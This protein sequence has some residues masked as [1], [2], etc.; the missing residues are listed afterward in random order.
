MSFRD[1]L[2]GSSW[3]GGGRIRFAAD[4]GAGGAGAGG[5]AAPAGGAPGGGGGG[6][7]VPEWLAPV[8][9]D[10]RTFIST[11]G[12]KPESPAALISSLGKGYIGAEKMVGVDKLP[13]PGKD[14][15][16]EVWDAAYDRLGRPKDGKYTA[17]KPEGA[18]ESYDAFVGR[19]SKFAHENG[20]NQKQFDNTLGFMTDLAKEASDSAERQQKEAYDAGV[21]KLRSEWGAKF[22]VNVETANRGGAWLSKQVPEFKGLIEQLGLMNEPI[23]IRAMQAVGSASADDSIRGSGGGSSFSKTPDEA[24]AEIAKMEGDKAG[25]LWNRGHPEHEHGREAARPIST[26]WRI[27]SRARASR[28]STPERN[29]ASRLMRGQ[30]GENHDGREEDRDQDDRGDHGEATRRRTSPAKREA[31]LTSLGALRGEG[32]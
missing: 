12:W 24:K 15:P 2:L 11:K 31:L 9:A 17:Q 23:F 26:R 18:G 27:R 22:D 30:R 14:S 21:A 13:V 25:P 5:E 1:R 6:D 3:T 7:T 29:P 4:G 32:G 16:Q 28:R 19:V 10:V 8:D 20:W